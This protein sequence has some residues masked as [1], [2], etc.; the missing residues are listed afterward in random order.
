MTA[1]RIAKLVNLIIADLSTLEL[2]GVPIT[3]NEKI[4]GLEGALSILKSIQTQELSDQY[5]RAQLTQ[6]LGGKQ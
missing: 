4:A 3:G 1:T 5:L 6:M 2:D